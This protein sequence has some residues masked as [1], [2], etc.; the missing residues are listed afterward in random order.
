MRRLAR[1]ARLIAEPGGAVAVAAALFRDP[2]ELGQVPGETVAPVVAVLSGGN[3]D[4]TLLA[5][6]LRD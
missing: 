6:I 4:P 3:I 2:A 1:E 5:D